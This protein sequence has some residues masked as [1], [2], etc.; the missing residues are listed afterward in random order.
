MKLSKEKK[1]KKGININDLL[2]LITTIV[3]LITAIINL[4]LA[5]SK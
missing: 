4:I 2:K 5:L 3:Q 1:K